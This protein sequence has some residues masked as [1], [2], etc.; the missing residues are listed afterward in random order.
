MLPLVLGFMIGLIT[1]EL[2]EGATKGAEY[3][4]VR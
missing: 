1:T 2:A 4:E 3:E